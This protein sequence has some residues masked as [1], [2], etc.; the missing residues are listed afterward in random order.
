MRSTLR[1]REYHAVTIV[2]LFC[3]A[4]RISFTGN[5]LEGWDDVDFAL[6]LG[7]FDLTLFQP[8][9]PGYILFVALAKAASVF[10]HNTV[11]ALVIPNVILGS[12]AT[13]PLYLLAGNI[14][15][16]HTAMLTI[17]L[18]AVNPLIWLQSER[19]LPD[20]SALFFIILSAQFMCLSVCR[21]TCGVKWTLAGSFTLGIALGIKPSYFPFIMSWIIVL[22][23]YTHGLQ[24]TGNRPNPAGGRRKILAINVLAMS[25][26]I[27][28]WAVPLLAVTGGSDLLTEGYNFTIGH[29][30]DWGG[31]IVTESDVT[32]RVKSIYW[33]ILVNGLGIWWP[34]T[35][36]VRI[37]PSLIIAML[38]L[39]FIFKTLKPHTC[40]YR[41]INY[42]GEGA[43]PQQLPP[44]NVHATAHTERTT[45]SGKCFILVFTVPYLTWLFFGQNLEHPRH[46]LPVIPFA[47]TA[48][49]VS[50]TSLAPRRILQRSATI[51]LVA[52][53]SAISAN[54]ITTFSNHVP[55]QLQLIK[56]VKGNADVNA[57]RI[58][59]ADAK[60]LFDYYAP[61]WDVRMVRNT[62]EMRDDLAMSLVDPE[63]VFCTSEIGGIK[64]NTK[65]LTL[66]TQFR[67]NRYINN[68]SATLSLYRVEPASPRQ[69]IH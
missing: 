52:A 24:R 34:D 57:T 23:S 67:E 47:L 56:F 11:T 60:R 9:F 66:I 50:I 48:L 51:I 25:F 5:H 1:T 21:L 37:I 3:F 35:S 4:T 46:A 45:M 43:A 28:I 61:V 6:S 68:Q 32:H 7:S 69:F 29:F 62:N 8:H 33:N 31:S 18:Y 53:F 13:I 55:S 59:C 58:Y 2:T 15:S 41:T 63:Y 10:V 44:D 16:R 17:I 14:F 64:P 30:A 38:S 54:L 49:S 39:L 42:T 36:R 40:R 26:G 22:W 19:P 20:I 27:A 65:G 12:L